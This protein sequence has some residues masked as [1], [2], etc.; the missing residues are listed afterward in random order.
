VRRGELAVPGELA[1]SGDDGAG[2]GGE[3]ASCAAAP[4]VLTVPEPARDG[5]LR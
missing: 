1:A 4:A 5:T 2:S 3:L